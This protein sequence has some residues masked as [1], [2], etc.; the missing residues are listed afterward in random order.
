VERLVVLCVLGC[1]GCGG[2]AETP[3]QKCDDLVNDLCNRGVSCAPAQ[4]GTHDNCVQQL[5]QILPCGTTKKVGTSYDRCVMQINGD[6]CQ[7]LFPTDP[8]TGQ[9][10][11]SLPADCVGVIQ[12]RSPDPVVGGSMFSPA[13]ALAAGAGE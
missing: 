3:V 4:T 9:V 8:Q 6:S 2:S 10:S 1:L 12:T 7:I 13:R 5:Q 11:V